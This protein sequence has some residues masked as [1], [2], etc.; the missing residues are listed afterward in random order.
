MNTTIKTISLITL[1]AV[2]GCATVKQAELPQGVQLPGSFTATADTTTYAFVLKDFFVD[3]KLQQLIDTALANNFDLKMALQR[4]EMARAHTH[5]ADA[6]RLPQVNAVAGLAVDRF[7]KYTLNGVGNYDTNL[8]P[9][10]DK[11]QKIPTPTPDYYLGFRSSWE[12]DLWGKLKDRRSAA[13][14]R[15]LA[16]QKGRQW[17]T[18]Q[19][20]TEVARLYYDLLALDGQQKIIRRNIELQNRGLEV[21]EAQMAG[22]RATA[23]AVQQFKAQV[24]H[25]RGVEVDIR[26]SIAKTENELNNLLGRFSIPIERDTSLIAKQIPGKIQAGIP[27]EALLQRPDIQQAELELLAAKA[28]TRAARKAFLPSLTL[29]PSLGLNAFK[30]P[31]LFSGASVAAGIAASLATP[32]LNRGALTS[33]VNIANAEQ[34][35]AFYQYQK[36]LV[37]GYQEVV[38]QLQSIDNFKQA[39]D[40]KTAEVKALMDGVS[41]ANDLYLSGYASYL[42]VIIAQGSVLQAEMEQTSLKKEIFQSV[43]NLYRSLGGNR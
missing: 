12:I 6:A 25:T 39:Y 14:A 8:S 33:G 1:V 18:T 4:I 17:L 2:T 9:N 7:G 38:T 13:Y 19:L 27:S 37:Q 29:N 43:I 30:V 28:D 40:L 10:I 5:I 26:R 42:E 24:L 35:A 31:L 32:V 41:Y 11:N 36:N 20:V 23:L 15:F 34:A 22:G 16:S 3:P 21:V